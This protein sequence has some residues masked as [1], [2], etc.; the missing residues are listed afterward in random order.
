MF[1]FVLSSFSARVSKCPVNRQ[2]GLIKQTSNFVSKGTITT[3]NDAIKKE[4]TNY[5]FRHKPIQ[6]GNCENTDLPNNL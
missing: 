6:D 1:T 3:E 2:Q 4:S 5:G